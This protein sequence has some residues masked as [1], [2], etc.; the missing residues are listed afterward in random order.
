MI[1]ETQNNPA[2]PHLITLENRNTLTVSGIT[3]ID[4]FDEREIV[5]YTAMG[6]LTVTGRELHI[7]AISIENGSLSV[8]GDIWSLQ[9]GDK[10][11]HSPVSM[12]GKLFR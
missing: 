3:D 8:E 9:Y 12:L 7:N 4:R 2:T 6:E 1:Q 11:K 5:L 10:D